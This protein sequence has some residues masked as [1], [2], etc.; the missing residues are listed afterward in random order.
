MP[1]AWEILECA[2]VPFGTREGPP[3][4]ASPEQLAA[5]VREVLD[6][7]TLSERQRVSLLA[8]LRA[9][10]SAWPS[11]FESTFAGAAN[12]FLLRAAKGVEDHGRYLKLRRLAR[13][14]LARVL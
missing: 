9:W 11:S 3:R 4:L 5:A 13:E 10:A 12:E 6:A 1:S 7:S 14:Q 8:W 2:G